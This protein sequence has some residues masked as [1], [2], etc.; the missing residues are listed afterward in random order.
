MVKDGKLQVDFLDFQDVQSIHQINYIKA[1]LS[2]SV[3]LWAKKMILSP[4]GI[5]K[6]CSLD[7]E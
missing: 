5:V 6:L 7:K 2:L 3:L 1:H 4:T